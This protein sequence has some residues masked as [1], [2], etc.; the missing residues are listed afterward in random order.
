[1]GQLALSIDTI[2]SG[3]KAA[4]LSLLPALRFGFHELLVNL[5]LPLS[6]I[7]V[8]VSGSFPESGAFLIAANH[9][10]H[11]DTVVILKGL[12]RK[13]R[14][15]LRIAA[16][17]GYFFESKNPLHRLAVNLFNLIPATG[18][19]LI[20]SLKQLERTSESLLLY[21]EGTRSRTGEIK[22]FCSGIGKMHRDS[23]IPVIPVAIRGNF[24]LMPVGAKWPIPGTVELIIGEPIVSNSM[25]SAEITKLVESRVRQLN[26]NLEKF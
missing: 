17:R 6:K 21:P 9:C 16:S 8:K 14:S 15:H 10:S 12:S 3:E 20:H 1:M 19:S 18:H 4:H 5:G 25:D 2:L 13:G 23:G 22:P 26:N 11:L 24:E 7:T